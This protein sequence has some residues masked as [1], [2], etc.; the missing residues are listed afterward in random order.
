[1]KIEMIGYNDTKAIAIY[2]N[3]KMLPYCIFSFAISILLLIP[4]LIFHIYELLFVFILPS[5][6]L[7]IMLVQ[8]IIN[9][10][11]K[12]FL[13][14]TKTKHKI[15]LEDGQLYKDGKRIKNIDDI[16]LYKFKSFLFLELKY[17]YYRIDNNDYLS[18][19]REEFLSNVRYLNKHYIYFDLPKKSND[20]IIDLLF[21]DVNLDGKERLFYSNDKTKIVYIYKNTSGSYSIGYETLTIFDEYERK[22]LHEYGV[23]EPSIEDNFATFYESVEAAY[24]DIKATIK[25]Y[26]EMI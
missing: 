13:K 22:Y 21:N 6:L 18:G 12:T 20:E 17:S 14:N 11:D 19:S 16:K 7:F 15:C 25:D 9:S 2:G 5:L 10:K 8:Y 1:M 24:N 23:W 26:I 3:I 4:S